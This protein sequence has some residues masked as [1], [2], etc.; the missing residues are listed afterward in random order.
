MGPALDG[1][2]VLDFAVAVDQPA[3][4]TATTRYSTPYYAPSTTTATTTTGD[5]DAG[6]REAARATAAHAGPDATRRPSSTEP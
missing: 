5:D 3:T 4:R 1:K 2:P 6:S